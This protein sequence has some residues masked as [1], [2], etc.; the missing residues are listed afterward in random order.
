VLTRRG[1]RCAFR[2][3][4]RTNKQA[5]DWLLTREEK[6]LPPAPSAVL[7]D[8]IATIPARGIRARAK[9]ALIAR[10]GFP[11]V[12]YSTN[13]KLKSLRI[14]RAFAFQ[15]ASSIRSMMPTG[16]LRRKF[17]DKS[18]VRLRTPLETYPQIWREMTIDQI[19]DLLKD[20]GERSDR[21]RYSELAG[22]G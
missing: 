21:H 14:W 17:P 6:G 15:A 1:R 19:L 12:P 8:W 16:R 3:I 11:D 20:D 18:A 13:V 22:F 7:L 9:R 4:F 10:F 2:R 5:L